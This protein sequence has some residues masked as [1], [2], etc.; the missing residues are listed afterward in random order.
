[1]IRSATCERMLKSR[2]RTVEN[3]V[4]YQTARIDRKRS[5]HSNGFAISVLKAAEGDSSSR[6]LSLIDRLDV[7]SMILVVVGDCVM[8]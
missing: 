5:A 6:K 7:S 8:H 2:W 4:R 1:M 3:T